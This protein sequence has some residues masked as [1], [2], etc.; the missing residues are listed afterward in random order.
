MLNKQM[1]PQADPMAAERTAVKANILRQRKLVETMG[2]DIK[3]LYLNI[4]S[5]TNTFVK[6]RAIRGTERRFC[7][8][9]A[10]R[11]DGV[12]GCRRAQDNDDMDG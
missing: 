12:F 1:L 10:V 7:C 3:V 6:N 5:A 9:N 4:E 2:W 11:Q 8:R